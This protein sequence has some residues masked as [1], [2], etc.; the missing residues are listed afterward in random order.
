MHVLCMNNIE[1]SVRIRY[2][3]LKTQMKILMHNFYFQN[4]NNQCT[5][6]SIIIHC[7]TVVEI[8]IDIKLLLGEKEDKNLTI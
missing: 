5:N 8:I 1:Q 3:D 6:K 7:N 4:A 2:Y